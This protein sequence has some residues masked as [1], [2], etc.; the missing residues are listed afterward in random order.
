[1]RVRN[2]NECLKDI[3]LSFSLRPSASLRKRLKDFL[4]QFE[5]D[6]RNRLYAIGIDYMYSILTGKPHL[7]DARDDNEL[8][9][10][11]FHLSYF[12]A[13]NSRDRLSY[14]VSCAGISLL[15]RE[16]IDSVLAVKMKILHMMTSFE[17]GYAAETLR[18]YRQLVSISD[19]IA[20][21]MKSVVHFELYNGLGLV[22]KL[23]T[24]EDPMVFYKKALSYAGDAAERAMVQMNMANHLYD[25]GDFRSALN[26]AR[27]VERVS[28]SQ[29]ISKPAYIRGNALFCQL[30]IHLQTG[31]L[32]SATSAA[33]KLE[34]L[35]S[36][37]PE[38][39][40]E[41]IAHVFLGHYYIAVGN[42]KEAKK[43]LE[44]LE[45]SSSTSKTK[46]IEGEILVLSAAILNKS[47]EKFKALERLVKAFDYLGIYKVVSPHLRDFVRNLLQSIMG[48]F[49]DLIHELEAKDNYTALHTLRV[50]KISYAVGKE[51]GLS[52][53]DLFYLALGAML[54]DYG[55]VDIPTSIL[56]KPAEL[57]KE[58][59][60][61]VRK[62]P[63]M[64]ARY[65]ENLA[66]P[67]AVRDIVLSHHERNDGLGYPQGLKDGEI[68]TLVQIVA[69][70]D[71]FDALT[72]DRPYRSAQEK[73]D[74]MN[75]LEEQG[76]TIV[77]PVVFEAFVNALE[78][79]EYETTLE[80]F[81]S[82]WNEI[83]FGL[84]L[85]EKNGA[86]APHAS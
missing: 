29:E 42:Q 78:V 74:A 80:E 55:K 77:E 46:Y 32:Q 11:L 62:H 48:I 17:M 51:L 56:N 43:Y 66:F 53:V 54:H 2:V 19:E 31:D 63:T 39:L 24:G 76:G 47:G 4:E 9:E 23:F 34:K 25:E 20:S 85:R 12:F 40:D 36:D 45:S 60:E 13:L 58:E 67:E 81:E 26:I 16:T 57:T 15:K 84:F 8:L 21:K 6:R 30:K 83:L 70:C 14:L 5:V 38:W 28:H 10:S 37:F 64:G 71:V 49:R 73:P 1:M 33:E 82:V 86:I 35:S 68:S 7:I 79:S 22:S 65:L 50:S 44:L 61:V 52:K 72:T 75:Y 18:W 3:L 27:Q 41:M 69:I 59:F